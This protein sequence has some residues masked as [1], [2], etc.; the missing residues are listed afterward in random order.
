MGRAAYAERPAKTGPSLYCKHVTQRHEYGTKTEDNASLV[1]EN[2][3][4]GDQRGANGDRVTV[5]VATDGELAACVTE[6]DGAALEELFRRHGPSCMALARRVVV[7]R[8]LAEEIVQEVFLRFWKAPQRY[9]S[10]RGSVRTFLMAGVHS[11]AIDAIRSERSRKARE[12]RAGRRG[13]SVIEIDEAL[14]RRGDREA[15]RRA[16]DA[17]T[18]DERAAITLA[19]F[20]GH[21][22]REV[23][24][25]L[26][27]PEGTVKSRIRQGLHRMQRAL[28]A[29]FIA[30]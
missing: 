6:G 19:Y 24:L 8:Q 2:A 21:S 3:L 27:Q 18:A 9:D 29:E 28:R 20:E 15:V 7:N 26:G 13:D 14:T 30:A 16:M 25:L 17:L 10:E 11:T 12:E 22:Y 1:L 4:D 5:V 23:A